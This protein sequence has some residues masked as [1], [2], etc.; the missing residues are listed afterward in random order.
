MCSTTPVPPV[1]C[2]LHLS[3][4][5]RPSPARSRNEPVHGSG[6]T[7]SQEREVPTSKYLEFAVTLQIKT[8]ILPSTLPTGLTH[9]WI[10]RAGCPSFPLP[11]TPISQ[12]AALDTGMEPSPIGPGTWLF[13]GKDC[14]ALPRPSPNQ[15]PGTPTI[16]ASP[17]PTPRPASPNQERL[18]LLSPIY[19]SQIRG[20]RMCRNASQGKM[21]DSLLVPQRPRRFRR[22]QELR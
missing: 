9:A 6:L 19:A 16:C 4:G 11:G 7:R 10:C 2:S 15:E 20:F 1:S 18:F 13:D 22:P 5:H 8:K 17:L 3:E 14:F 21:A 12:L